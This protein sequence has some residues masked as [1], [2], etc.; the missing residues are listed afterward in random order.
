MSHPDKAVMNNATPAATFPAR[1]KVELAAARLQHPQ[2][3]NS[4]H[5]GYSIVLE[6]LEEFWEEVRKRKSERNP[7]LMLMELLQL[8]AMAQRCAEDLGLIEAPQ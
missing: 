7:E 5:E 2:P 3:F 1:V 8:G 6:E 4:A